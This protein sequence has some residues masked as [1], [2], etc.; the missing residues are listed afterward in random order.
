MG[1][2]DFR[3]GGKIFATLG[4]PDPDRGMVK[5]TP[6]EQEL[7]V[8]IEPKGFQPVRGSW[9]RQG[10]TNVRLRSAKKNTVREALVAAWRNRA[11]KSLVPQ[12]AQIS[13]LRS[14]RKKATGAGA[15]LEERG[16]VAR[17]GGR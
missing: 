2:P 6:D 7:F 17:Q 8:Q 9:G 12:L 10:A 15:G 4:A 5:L 13:G 16:G 3:V 14:R 1:H 11:P